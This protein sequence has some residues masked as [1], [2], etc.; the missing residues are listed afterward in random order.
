M[1]LG[2]D[3]AEFPVFAK[4][5]QH[6]LPCVCNRPRVNATM[7]VPFPDMLPNPFSFCLRAGELLFNLDCAHGNDPPRLT[8]SENK[9]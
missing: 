6:S 7:A 1:K 4:A 9:S 8:G 3:F 5:F 2:I